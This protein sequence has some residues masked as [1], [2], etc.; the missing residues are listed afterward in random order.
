M[1][2]CCNQ[3]LP[4]SILPIFPDVPGPLPRL[5]PA[6]LCS[7]LPLERWPSPAK[8]WVGAL[9]YPN[10]HFRWESDIGAVVI[11]FCS[12]PSVCSPHRWLP[13]LHL[14]M[15]SGRG[16]YSRAYH[17]W[18]PAPCCGYANR[19]IRAI[20]GKGTSTPLDRQPCRLLPS[21]PLYDPGWSGWS[22][23]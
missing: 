22:H 6:C 11:S 5:P 12:G 15:P 21:A 3:D 16:F 14:L 23:Q 9:Q 1:S 20:D 17:G 7:F 18:L 19:P 2:P 10:S 8:E 4:D 13:P